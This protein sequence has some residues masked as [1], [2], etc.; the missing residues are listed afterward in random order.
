MIVERDTPGFTM[1]KPHYHMSGSPWWELFFDN[2][3]V[4]E[5]NV[6]FSAT[7]FAS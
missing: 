1:S 7:G 6:L 3:E 4:P 2:A 5:E